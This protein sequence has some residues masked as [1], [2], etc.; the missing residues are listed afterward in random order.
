MTAMKAI[1]LITAGVLAAQ[2]GFVPLFNG[3]NLDGWEGAA[4]LW[5]VENGVLVGSSD[6]R[7]IAQNTFLI[8]RKP[9]ADFILRFDVKL[10]NGNSGMQFRSTRLENFVVTGY[11]A[12]VS[13][14]G[15]R[16]AWG[17]FYEEKGRGRNVMKTP[18]EGWQKAK[19]VLRPGGWNSY[20][21][22]AQGNRIR[23]TF[24]GVVTID[25]TD[26]KARDGVIAIQLHMGDP[27]RVE[28]RNIRIKPL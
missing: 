4:G 21:V 25:T 5:S 18:D 15:D 16:S 19:S 17:N 2:D 11:Q 23:L 22:F 20:E 6:G 8:Y 12:D 3:K 14:A 13:D 9:F 10:R 28:Y 27:M 24:N 26:D 7:K 1:W